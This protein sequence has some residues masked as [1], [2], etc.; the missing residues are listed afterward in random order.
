MILE[1]DDDFSDQVVVNVLADSYVS[2]KSM[3]KNGIVYHEDDVAAYEEMLPAIK[4][5]GNWFS[6][7]FAAE[8]KKANKRM[9]KK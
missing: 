3:L 4:T 5:V 8:I 1:I 9:N 6:T 7:D 2:M